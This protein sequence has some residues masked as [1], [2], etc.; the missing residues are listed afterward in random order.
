MQKKSSDISSHNAESKKKKL[1][2][3]DDG[4][5]KL[6]DQLINLNAL[7]QEQNAELKKLTDTS[8]AREKK[9]EEMAA[10]MV[11]LLDILRRHESTSE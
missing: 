1:H 8:L 3:Q 5:K 2:S 10:Q 9:I 7:Y 11:E 4:I 6:S